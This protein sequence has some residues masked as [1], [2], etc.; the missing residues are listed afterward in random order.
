LLDMHTV[1]EVLLGLPVMADL[2][3]GD[4]PNVLIFFFK[5]LTPGMTGHIREWR[6]QGRD[7]HGM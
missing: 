7:S 3:R 5:I 4:S 6:R 2:R 1:R